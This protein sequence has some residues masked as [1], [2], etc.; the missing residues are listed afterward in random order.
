MA[1]QPFE[2]KSPL[3]GVFKNGTYTDHPVEAAVDALNVLPFDRQGRNRVAQRAGSSKLWASALGSGGLVQLLDQTTIA[4][5]PTSITADTLLGSDSFTYSVG[6]LQT[7]AT[8]T[9]WK[10]YGGGGASQ[11]T[12]WNVNASGEVF[13][14]TG[15]SVEVAIYQPAVTLGTAYVLKLTAKWAA[16]ERPL[17]NIATRVNKTTPGAGPAGVYVQFSGNANG[18][19]GLTAGTSPATTGLLSTVTTPLAIINATAGTS[20]FEVRVNGDVFQV[21]IDGIKYAQFT[22]SSSSGNSG[23]G[24]ARG[25]QLFTGATYDTFQVYTGRNLATYRQTN[26]VGVSAGSIFEGD[27]STQAT[28]VTGGTTQL[29]DSI[30]PQGGSSGG[31]Y[32]F[33]D[34]LNIRKLDI[35]THAMET[36]TATA[37]TAPS[38]CTVACFYRDRLVLGAPRDTPQ[39]FFFSRVGTHTDWDYTQTDSATAFAGNASIAGRIGEPIVALMPFSDDILL[40]G[41]DH[42]LWAMRGDPADG[43]SID[44]VSDAIGMLGP[45]AWTKA[46]DGTVFFVG[47]G[48]FFKMA[49]GSS[50]PVNLSSDKWNDFFRTINRASNYIRVA[51]DRDRQGAY[52]F[53][54]PVTSGTATH[55]WYDLPTGGFWPL[56][57]PNTFGPVT[58]LVYDGDGPDDRAALLGTRNGYIQKLTQTDKSDDGTAISSRVLIG[59]YKNSDVTEAI[60]EWIDVILGE[61]QTGFA[62]SDYNVTASVLAGQTAEKAANN[63]LYTRSRTF[64]SSRRQTKW[65]NRTRG[66]YFFLKLS[67]AVLNKTFN[68][69]KAVAMFLPGGMVRRR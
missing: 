15:S 2:F 58:A 10:T 22:S 9:N 63:P 27:I 43:G 40:I 12:V 49:P 50:L 33:V 4:L 68:F 32:Y 29:S 54:T 42:N 60:L 34:G 23:I 16:S 67:N 1:N 44:M 39:N 65:I 41:G 30:I 7:V 26:L 21:Y 18:S 62:D 19:V 61:P 59:P 28:V 66:A 38:F 36:Y 8:T 6:A 20:V 37:G 13:V 51:W 24:F 52:I 35:A 48:G 31:K 64:T 17:I 55:L 14:N 56:Q 69:E 3:K 45:N 46:P 47:T 11:L 53:I 57:F 25:S 5:D